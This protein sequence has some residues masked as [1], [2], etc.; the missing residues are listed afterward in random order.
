[1]KLKKWKSNWKKNL[2]M[3]GVLAA[4]IIP[5]ANPTSAAAYPGPETVYIYTNKYVANNTQYKSTGGTFKVDITGVNSGNSYLVQLMEYDPDGGHDQVGPTQ[6]W[7]GNSSITWDVSGAV[8]GG[9]G[10]E[11]YILIGYAEQ[12]DTV[13]LQ[14][15]D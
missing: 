9:N 3:V 7:D 10:A 8:D 12:N 2:A 1:M 15:Y 5:N 6:R 11:L 13:Y 14:A 4:L